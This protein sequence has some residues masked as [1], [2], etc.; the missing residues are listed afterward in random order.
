MTATLTGLIEN[1]E[2]D[3]CGRFEIEVVQIEAGGEKCLLGCDCAAKH[4][5]PSNT[6]RPQTRTYWRKKAL[7]SNGARMLDEKLGKSKYVNS[8]PTINIAVAN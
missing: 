6:D 5:R 3:Y 1:A 8:Y 2:C 4:L 7:S